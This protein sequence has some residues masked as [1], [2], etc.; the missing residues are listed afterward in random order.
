MVTTPSPRR[1]DERPPPAGGGSPARRTGPGERAPC[2]SRRGWRDQSTLGKTPLTSQ[3]VNSVVASPAATT[4]KRDSER[5]VLSFIACGT[6]LSNKTGDHPALPGG[7]PPPIVAFANP[8][9]GPRI[10]ISWSPTTTSPTKEAHIGLSEAP[11][12]APQGITQRRGQPLQIAA[13]EGGIG[14]HVPR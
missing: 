3:A 5:P 14:L 12:V 6:P 7:R 2:G 8:S 4:S 10:R 9:L 1:P 13:S 11:I